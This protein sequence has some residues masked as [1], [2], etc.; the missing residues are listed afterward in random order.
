VISLFFGHV[1]QKKTNFTSITVWLDYAIT[2]R[3]LG[4][5]FLCFVKPLVIVIVI[6]IRLALGLGIITITIKIKLDYIFF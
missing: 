5:T 6:V 3:V 2:E 4:S 1:R